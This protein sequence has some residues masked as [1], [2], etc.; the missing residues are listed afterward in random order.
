MDTTWLFNKLDS[1]YKASTP[2]FPC[3]YYNMLAYRNVAVTGTVTDRKGHPIEGAVVR[4]WNEWWGVGMNTYTDADG[5]FRLVSNDI[6]VHFEISAPGYSKQKFDRSPSYPADLQLPDRERE[7]QQM[8]LTGWG[9]S[10]GRILPHG[11]DER[12]EAPTA[13]EASIGNITLIRL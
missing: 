1:E 5:R 10:D 7:Y 4:G 6:C 13:V 2:E 9:P 12:Y 8:P 11:S 3:N